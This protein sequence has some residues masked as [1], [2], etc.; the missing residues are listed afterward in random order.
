MIGDKLDQVME[1]IRI[2]ELL[3]LQSAIDKIVEEGERVAKNSR[4]LAQIDVY[5]S[6]AQTA[7]ERQL[8][9]PIVVQEPVF[10]VRV[11]FL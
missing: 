6:L 1:A 11:R 10:E 7:C 5:A 4:K 9:R 8:A 2:E 3:I